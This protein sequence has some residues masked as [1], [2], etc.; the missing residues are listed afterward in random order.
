MTAPTIDGV[1]LVARPAELWAISRGEGT[2]VTRLG[3]TAEE[4]QVVALVTGWAEAAGAR[5]CGPGGE[6]DR[7]VAPRTGGD[8][9]RAERAGDTPQPG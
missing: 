9:L 4:R 5:V 6:H 2:G 3:W 8:D 1:R 7:R